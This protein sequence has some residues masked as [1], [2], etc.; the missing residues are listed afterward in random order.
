VWPIHLNFLF[1]ISKFISFS[2]Y[3]PVQ[4]I[5]FL[6][7]YILHNLTKYLFAS[8]SVSFYKPSTQH[9]EITNT[10]L[11][12]DTSYPG[13]GSVGMLSLWSQQQDGTCRQHKRGYVHFLS[14]ALKLTIIRFSMQMSGL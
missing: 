8:P 13:Y 1:L 14:H 2:R 9:R 3:N 5:S 7:I 12:Q 6:S 11:G 4:N 10:N